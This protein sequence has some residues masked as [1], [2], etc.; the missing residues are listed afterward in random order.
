MNLP[1]YMTFT[2]KKFAT[3][4]ALSVLASSPFLASADSPTDAF[5][6]S[7]GQFGTIPGDGCEQAIGGSVGDRGCGEPRGI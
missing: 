5:G 7:G 3:A 6:K 2:A 1:V 4:V